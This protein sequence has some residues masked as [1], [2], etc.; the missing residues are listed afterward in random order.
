MLNAAADRTNGFP[1]SKL[2]TTL[3]YRFMGQEVCDNRENA[4]HE[5]GSKTCVW[6]QVF[7]QPAVLFVSYPFNRFGH[8]C[9]RKSNVG[10]SIWYGTPPG[11][12]GESTTHLMILKCLGESGQLTFKQRNSNCGV[13][14]FASE[15]Q[16]SIEWFY[17]SPL[18]VHT[19]CMKLY[20]T[21]C[22]KE[23]GT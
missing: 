12:N 21:L 17:R 23:E 3:R 7:V 6:L 4:I 20:P 15:I 2:W 9:P 14:N 22:R 10:L 8:F 1:S 11:I 16:E 18:C 19:K 5:V 13:I